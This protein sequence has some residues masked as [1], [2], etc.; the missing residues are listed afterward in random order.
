MNTPLNTSLLSK[1][2]KPKLVRDNIPRII[3]EKEPKSTL[4]LHCADS[5]EF[6]QMVKEKIREEV[7]ELLEAK[8]NLEI[9]E[10][11]SDVYEII[12]TFR[13]IHGIDEATLL[14]VKKLR[15]EQRGGFKWPCFHKLTT[16]CRPTSR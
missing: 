3:L 10:E 14:A 13:D 7:L 1:S 4:K 11:L 6:Y 8:N 16:R 9:S 5:E 15:L 12:E 2:S